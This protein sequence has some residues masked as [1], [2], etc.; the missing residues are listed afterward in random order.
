MSKSISTDEFCKT[1]AS[2]KTFCKCLINTRLLGFQLCGNLERN[3]RYYLL[4]RLWLTSIT[5]KNQCQKLKRYMFL[6]LTYKCRWLVLFLPMEP[7]F[8][9]VSFDWLLNKCYVLLKLHFEKAGKVS[10]AVNWHRCLSFLFFFWWLSI[11]N[12]HFLF[13]K[14][15]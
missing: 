13:M 10:V 11:N 9:S 1:F 6:L 8:C 2:H 3:K 4:M 5:N 14:W 7:G 15:I 12:V